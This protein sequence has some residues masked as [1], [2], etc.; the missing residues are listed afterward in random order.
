MN[1][2]STLIETAGGVVALAECPV[3][4]SSRD[5]RKTSRLYAAPIAPFTLSMRPTH[6]VCNGLT[7][8]QLGR[9]D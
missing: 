9:R 2:L 3:D 8:S 6:A 1:I 4:R 7:A 5:L